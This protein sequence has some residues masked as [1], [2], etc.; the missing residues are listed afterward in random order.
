MWSLALS[1]FAFGCED[2]RD[3]VVAQLG[4][5]PVI[6]SP[7]AGLMVDITEDNLNDVFATISWT[8]ADFGFT[9]AVNYKV[10]FDVAG[11]NFA[12]AV[13]LGATTKFDLAVSNTK[14]NNIMVTKGL[15]G[16]EFTNME[17]RVRARTSAAL[18]ELI[19]QAITVSVS[20][21]AVEIDYPK[22]QV[23]GSYQGWAPENETTVIYSANSDGKF[24]GYLYIGD[25]AAAHKFTDGPSW[26]VNWGD[27]GADGTLEPGGA[28]I[29]L[30]TAGVYRFVVDI[31]ALTHSS[32]RT[33]W[34]IIGDAT[35]GGWDNDTDMTYDQTTGLW[36]VDI[37]LEGGKFVKFRV[38]DA[39][40]VN[41]GDN[42]TDNK[43]EYGGAD[44][45][46]AE[47]GNYTVTLDLN[48]AIYTYTLTK[49]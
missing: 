22:L 7:E 13:E 21:V 16:G 19:S 5:A 18:D 17:I 2:D 31:N 29:V 11:N 48:N 23:P 12:D 39:W 20:P 14:V 37:D 6:T 25:D 40:D 33:E 24:D 41:L 38:N 1:I 36:T 10:E 28:D 43:M 42:D 45:P 47:S 32:L 30:G 26:D 4:D 44:I 35:P 34:G 15:P 3:L 46:V 8:P 9:A 49:N 27:D